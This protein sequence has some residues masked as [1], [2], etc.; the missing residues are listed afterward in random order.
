MMPFWTLRNLPMIWR[1]TN[2][3]DAVHAPIP[4]DVG[5]IGNV[6]AIVL[7]K[8]L[9]VRHCGNWLAPKTTAEK[10]WRW[11][12]EEFAGGR[13]VMMATGGTLEPPSPRNPELKWIFSTSLTATELAE[14][15]VPRRAPSR[16]AVRLIIVARQEKAKGAGTVIAALPLLARDFPGIAFD[17][18]GEGGA[19]PEFRKQA[20]KL[21]VAERVVF[22]GNVDH[23]TV[24]TLLRKA[25][26]FCFPTQASDGFPKA[27]LEGLACGLPAVATRVSVLPLLLSSGCGKLVNDAT[28]EAVAE[29]IRYCLQDGERYEQLS[30]RALETARQYSLENWRDTIGAALSTEWGP[31]KES[32][33]A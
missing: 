5:T 28:P 31:L 11:F 3:A 6:L 24:L 8:P 14:H 23:N 33:A 4:G 12:M 10:L 32:H 22:H 1:L 26:L 30:L 9:F 19:V 17:V 25:H 7:R 20:E 16:D 15:A 27:V 13:N 18:V 29:A 2:S 21:G